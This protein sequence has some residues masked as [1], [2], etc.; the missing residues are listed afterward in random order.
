M[1]HLILITILIASMFYIT[2]CSTLLPKKTTEE[3]TAIEPDSEEPETEP[4]NE[5]EKFELLN[6]SKGEHADKAAFARQVA[7]AIEDFD[8]DIVHQHRTVHAR[9]TVG[10]GDLNQLLFAVFACQFGRN[11]GQRFRAHFLVIDAEHPKL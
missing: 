10:L 5:F 8:G 1:K 7:F 9:T 11:M 6:I 4:E 2:S 3:P